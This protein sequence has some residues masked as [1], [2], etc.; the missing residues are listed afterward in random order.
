MQRGYRYLF[1]SLVLTAALAAPVAICATAK[2]QENGRQ[3]E[4]RQD[5]NKNRNNRVYDRAHKDYHNWD[6]RED[7]AY[8]GYLQDNHKQYRPFTEQK[9]KQQQTYWNWRHSHPDSDRG[10]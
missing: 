3:E 5:D 1:S 2:P 10:E 4:N 6:D 9:Q 8:R 7:H